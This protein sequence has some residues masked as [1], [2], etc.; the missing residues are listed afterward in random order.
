MTAPRD[1]RF[2]AMTLANDP[3]F[4]RAAS[5]GDRLQARLA[6]SLVARRTGIDRAVLQDAYVVLR[7]GPVVG[8]EVDELKLQ[9][10]GHRFREFIFWKL[11]ALD[12]ATYPIEQHRSRTR[13][14]TYE[15]H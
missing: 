13:E 4:R 7:V 2:A 15:R 3:R 11:A 9:T 8:V 1:Y 12:A 14:V 6:A 5:T 10:T